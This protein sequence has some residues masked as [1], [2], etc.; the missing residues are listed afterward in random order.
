MAEPAQ[1][2]A[3]DNV[4]GMSALMALAGTRLEQDL[5]W[6]RTLSVEDRAML[7]GVV[8]AAVSGFVTWCSKGLRSGSFDPISVED[9]FRTAPPA[10]MRSVSLENTL[11]LVRT[12]VDVV[13]KSS[14]EIAAPGSETAVHDAT[15]RYAREV[16][17][18]AAGI[19]ARAAEARGLWDSRLES[20]ILEALARGESDA[21]LESRAAALGWTSSRAV[22]P[23][24]A[25]L[26]AP[27]RRRRARG[28]RASRPL[29]P[30]QAEAAALSA[31]RRTARSTAGDCL[32][33]VHGSRVIV[34]VPAAASPRELARGLLDALGP[35]PVVV[36][37]T[38]P[39]L[40][41]AG[42]A[43]RT[44][45]AAHRAAL[46]WPAAPRPASTED[47]LPERVLAGDAHAR[48]QIVDRVWRPLARDT[49]SVLETLGAYLDSGHSLDAS[50]RAL[51]VHPN[52]VR[53]RLKKVA[54]LTGWDPFDARDAFALTVALEV[55]RLDDAD[56]LPTARR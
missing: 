6:Y 56:A 12:L 23:I 53:Y 36:G 21:D 8:Q 32:A 35:G 25:T 14:G 50:S 39:S 28:A 15:L 46:A 13:E 51:F 43:L 29:D 42:D 9:V 55:G 11:Q 49:G 18:S 10:L 4:S 3:R 27:P 26:P 22:A 2:P 41:E 54:D 7:V 48:A 45:L 52:T 33:G 40:A 1:S 24:V 44:T 17:F 5:P 38:S 16:A 19:Y 37:E 31:L 47:L 34:V 20:T 30:Q